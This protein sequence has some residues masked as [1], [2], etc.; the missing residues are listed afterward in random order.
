MQTVDALVMGRNSYEKALTFGQWPYKK[1]VVVLS[2]RKLSIPQHLSGA[3][4][5]MA[6]SP[7][8]VVTRLSKRGARH[9]YVD[10]GKTI[11]GFLNAGLLQR[12]VL[13]RIPVLIGRGIPLFGLLSQDIRL[14]HVETRS[15][16]NGLVQS[17]YEIISS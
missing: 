6:G 1:P 17:T 15:F 2:T 8:E 12:L 14:R 3:V 13:T 4:E 5:A 16:A 11:Q 9:L 10:G 7:A